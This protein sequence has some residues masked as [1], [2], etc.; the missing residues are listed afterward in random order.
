[1][2]MKNEKGLVEIILIIA[3]IAILAILII[4]T[5]AIIYEDISYEEKEGIIIDKYYKKAYTT[6]SVM[7]CG[8]VM[9]PRTIHYPETWNFKIE[10]E[11]DGKKKSITIT[12]SE[13]TYNLYNIGDYYKKE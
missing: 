6:T 7:M 3:V 4:G 12:V 2:E 9:V 13:D 8:K 10:K 5:G 1:M 11:I